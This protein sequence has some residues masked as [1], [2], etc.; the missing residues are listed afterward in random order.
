[1]LNAEECTLYAIWED[2]NSV[3]FKIDSLVDRA[4]TFLSQE[5]IGGVSNL[6]LTIGV[7]TTLVSLLA[8]LAIA[9]K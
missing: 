4:A 1:M 8:I 7:I 6:L 2:T 5:S 9:R 3:S